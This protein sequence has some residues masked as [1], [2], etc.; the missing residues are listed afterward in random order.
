MASE[1]AQK[2]F[3]GNMHINTMVIEFPDNKSW[4]TFELGHLKAIMEPDGT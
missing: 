4:V 1:T 2:A 3:R